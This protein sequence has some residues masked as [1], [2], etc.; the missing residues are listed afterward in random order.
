M[1][2][3]PCTQLTMEKSPRAVDCRNR[4]TSSP[5]RKRGTPETVEVRCPTEPPSSRTVTCCAAPVGAPFQE[6]STSND[7]NVQISPPSHATEFARH[8]ARTTSCAFCVI[9]AT[10]MRSRVVAE[11]VAAVPTRSAASI[12]GS[13]STITVLC[14]ISCKCVFIS[15]YLQHSSRRRAIVVQCSDEQRAHARK[16][17]ARNL[18]IEFDHVGEKSGDGGSRDADVAA[19]RRATGTAERIK[20][21]GIEQVAVNTQADHSRA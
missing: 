2:N 7:V 1:R 8:C 20:K 14:A 3:V 13:R 16:S 6:S 11:A 17:C 19:V 15:L 9:F 21:S 5:G 10:D 18:Q 12:A 4:I